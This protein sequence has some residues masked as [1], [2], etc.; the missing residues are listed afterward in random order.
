ME[1]AT[2]MFN[3]GMQLDTHP[4]TQNNDTLTDCLNGTLITQ[5][6]NEV[7]LQNDMGNRRVDNAFLPAGYQPVGMK[8]Y[9]GIIYVAA[10]N[11]ITNKSQIG[12]FPSPQKKFN[13][14]EN[15]KGANLNLEEFF[16]NTFQ[17]TFD[18]ILKDFSLTFIKSDNILIP[19]IEDV[20]MYPGD[21]FVV[22]CNSLDSNK[23]SNFNN[24]EDGKIISPKNKQ[25]T[26]SLGVLNSQNEFVDI[27]SSLNR[28]TYDNG[29]ND[30]EIIKYPDNTSKEY[31]FND[32]YFIAKNFTNPNLEETIDDTEFI[33]NRQAL[34]INT[35]SFK[36]VG[37]LYLKAQIN[38]VEN[39]DYNITGNKISDTEYNLFIDGFFTYNCPDSNTISFTEG[40]D[41]YKT[42]D[43]LTP[44]LDGFYFYS[45]AGGD[46][47]SSECNKSVYDKTYNTYKLKVSKVIYINTQD[48]ILNYLL[49]VPVK[50]NEE[51][52]SSI[53]RGQTNKTKSTNYFLRGLT[54]EGS[55][56]LSLLNSGSHEL[57]GW[58]FFNDIENENT[59][60][61]YS[62][63]LYPKINHKFENLTITINGKSL[64]NISFNSS[65]T[66]VINWKDFGL[67]KQQ[68][69]SVS[70]QCDDV[71]KITNKVTNSIILSSDDLWIL[72]T[73]LFN[74]CFYEGGANYIKNYCKPIGGIETEIFNKKITVE[75]D[76]T[77]ILQDDSV[78]SSRIEGSIFSNNEDIKYSEIKT[79]NLNLNSSNN[80]IKAK[81]EEYYPEY[82]INAINQITVSPQIQTSNIDNIQMI[83]DSNNTDY[84]ENKN[85]FISLNNNVLTIRYEMRAHG[86]INSEG[87][88]NV[89]VPMSEA[90][91][92]MKTYNS[93]IADRCKRQ[94]DSENDADGNQYP[95]FGISLDYVY[96]GGYLNRDNKYVKLIKSLKPDNGFLTWTGEDYNISG[97]AQIKHRGL[98]NDNTKTLIHCLAVAD[99]FTDN[100]FNIFIVKENQDINVALNGQNHIIKYDSSYDN[101]VN[102]TAVPIKSIFDGTNS[103]STIDECQNFSWLFE[104][105][106]GD[107]F[108]VYGYTR[109]N[110]EQGITTPNNISPKNRTVVWWKCTNNTWAVSSY[111]ISKNSFDNNK[112]LTEAIFGKDFYFCHYS[113]YHNES[114]YCPEPNSIKTSRFSDDIILGINL[115][116]SNI[117]KVNNELLSFNIKSNNELC[118]HKINIKENT[119]FYDYVNKINQGI[120]YSLLDLKGRNTDSEG[121]ELKIGSIYIEEDGKLKEINNPFTISSNRYNT[122]QVGNNSCRQIVCNNPKYGSVKLTRSDG[123]I[124]SPTLVI[125]LGDSNATGQN[126]H[127]S[128]L[129]LIPRLDNE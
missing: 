121:H 37:P 102:F 49:T 53:G 106:D 125:H 110:T 30:S 80:K 111:L 34:P 27:T 99:R 126:L 45:S 81:N 101:E 83:N 66:I 6:G 5:N 11:P 15:G 2:N 104:P 40:D 18:K 90:I 24:T 61:K 28:W 71:D 22:Y 54:S 59:E 68:V 58:R 92:N 48:T 26:L 89:F 91:E 94:T 117:S 51:I 44:N 46:I 72:T 95:Y 100:F 52:P 20:N 105:A 10:Y 114:L 79:I 124:N 42:Y 76:I 19:L 75:L 4:M 35:Y 112:S 93:E 115:N 78:T 47:I 85:Y 77:G 33:R 13:N 84:G 65:G 23:I 14:I 128:N 86:N 70:L 55:L 32:G 103:R 108:I 41:L 56:D 17:E 113:S 57:T 1:Q 123:G 36:L 63:A 127:F 64:E 129:P 62:F 29:N 50:F 8:E 60:I 7:I 12:S 31:K 88:H 73:P 21:K 122:Y 3:K 98:E 74:D 38:H 25:Y 107:S 82:V 109:T 116:T 16:I 67:D 120:D 119:R 9:G 39:F 118:E 43:E 87:L 69:Y 97:D 96:D